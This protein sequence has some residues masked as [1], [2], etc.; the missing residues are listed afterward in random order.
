MSENL[1]ERL[2]ERLITVPKPGSRPFEP[3]YPISYTYVTGEKHKPG[4]S[5]GVQM[6]N[7]NLT[8]ASFVPSHFVAQEFVYAPSKLEWDAAAEIER[9]QSKL[10]N[11]EP[12]NTYD[13]RDIESWRS[14]AL[15]M[16]SLLRRVLTN[17]STTPHDKGCIC[18]LCEAKELLGEP[19]V[20]GAATV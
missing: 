2:R 12:I 14:E 15:R 19:P 17:I 6:V 4:D 7:V 18:E 5:A 13:N 10:K 8:A 1:V 9:L 20:K 11:Y 3:T 16:R